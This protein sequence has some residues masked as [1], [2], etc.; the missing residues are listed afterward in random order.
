MFNNKYFWTF[1]LTFFLNFLATLGD[2]SMQSLNC[3]YKTLQHFCV[4][5]AA[6]LVNKNIKLGGFFR[7]SA[8]KAIYPYPSKMSQ[9]CQWSDTES[10]LLLFDHLDAAVIIDRSIWE[11]IW[12]EAT[13]FLAIAADC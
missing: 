10:P 2:F 6:Y 7:P 12:P 4:I 3:W 9:G 13:P 8:A 5:E 11:V 1:Y